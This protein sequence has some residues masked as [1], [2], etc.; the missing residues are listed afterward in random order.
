MHYLVKLAKNAVETYIKK[1]ETVSPPEELPDKFLNKKAGTFVTL[2]K[3]GELRA[4][5][6]TSLP[7]QDN[8]AEEVI[9]NAISA[10]TKDT[11]FGAVRQEELSKLSYEVYV[12]Q[13]PV[14]VEDI[15]ELEPEKFG[16]IVKSID[17]NKSALLLPDLEGIDSIEKQF[18]VVCRKAGINPK[19]ERIQLLKFKAEKF[20]D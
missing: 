11:R 17:S 9:H 10:A 1:E 20:G 7:V 3:E 14:T 12:L 19:Q 15:D 8:I 6:G 2:K 18:L 5:I 16:V 4:C 13:K